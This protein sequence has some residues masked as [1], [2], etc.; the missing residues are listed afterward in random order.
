MMG[1]FIHSTELNEDLYAVQVDR[2]NSYDMNK[3][4]FVQGDTDSLTFAISGNINRGPEKLF[5]EVIKDYGFFD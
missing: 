3:M 4:H 1:G 5:E 2:E